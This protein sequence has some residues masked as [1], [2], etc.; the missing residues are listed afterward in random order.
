MSK[1]KETH[2]WASHNYKS[3]SLLYLSPI[4]TRPWRTN[5]SAIQYTG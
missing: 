2:F 1:L 4:R 5:K 3:C